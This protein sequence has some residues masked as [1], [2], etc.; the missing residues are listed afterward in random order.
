MSNRAT[1]VEVEYLEQML[2]CPKCKTHTLTRKPIECTFN[3]IVY[4]I[5]A[6]AHAYRL[7]FLQCTSCEQFFAV[8]DH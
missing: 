3:T 6:P 4:L 7:A 8:E 1:V 2:E 5:G